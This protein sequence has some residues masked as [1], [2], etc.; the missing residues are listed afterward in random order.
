M[1]IGKYVTV[2]WKAFIFAQKVKHKKKIFLIVGSGVTNYE[3]WLA[4]DKD[5]F[6]ITNREIYVNLLKGKKISKVLA[7]HVFEHLSQE[8]LKKALNN[9]YEFL[10][11]EGVLRI[12]VPDGFHKDKK[13]IN[14]VKPSGT[15]PG[16]DDHKHLF[17]YQS[18][19]NLLKGVGFD[20]NLIEYWDES[21]KFHS[22]YQNDENGYIQRSYINDKRNSNGNP[23]YTSLII[24]AIKKKRHED[25]L[26]PIVL[27][28]YSRPEHTRKTVE[29]LKKNILAINSELFIFS[30]AAKNDA[31]RQNVE[32]VRRYIQTIAGFKSI[33]I[34]EREENFGLAKSIISGIAEIINQHKKVI[35][36]ED[37]LITSPI[38]LNYMNHYLNL[39]KNEQNVFSITGFNYPLSLL[40][41]PDKY[42][43]NIY[44]NYRCMSWSWA[45]WI[46]R[47]N[48]VDWGVREYDKFIND[49][50]EQK[51]FN[52]GGDDLTDMLRSQIEGK[53]DSWA[54]RWCYAHFKNDAYCAYPVKSLVNNIGFDETGTHCGKTNRFAIKALSENLDFRDPPVIAVNE[55]LAKQVRDIYGHNWKIRLQKLFRRLLNG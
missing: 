55:N 17:T 18:L 53:I 54:I 44:F 37:D 25:N 33:T 6:D 14:A 9:I 10:E 34:I 51:L 48:K 41:V 16:A 26:A 47:W 11:I 5:F 3:G 15:G 28:V 42:P 50:E 19:G 1:L 23:N 24:D 21:R 49:K 8:D 27:F 22:T 39:Y 2:R 52:R 32:K 38:F 30:D 31:E 20:I 40:H 29:A 12:A 36:L 13:Y 45:T 35:V 46:D 7:E 4:T 43:Y